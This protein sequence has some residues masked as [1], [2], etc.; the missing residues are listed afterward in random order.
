M[1]PA[2]RRPEPGPQ[3]GAE[4]RPLSIK[5]EGTFAST[6]KQTVNNGRHLSYAE[7]SAM[8]AE[9]VAGRPVK[10]A[11][12]GGNSLATLPTKHG[13]SGECKGGRDV[14]SYRRTP[15]E[16]KYPRRDKDVTVCTTGGGHFITHP[17]A[18]SK[19]GG[20]P[21]LTAKGTGSLSVPVA[22]EEAAQRRT[23]PGAPGDVS[24]PMGGTPTTTTPSNAQVEKVV[25][26]GERRNKTPVCVS[27]VKNPRSFRNVF[28]QSPRA[29][30]WPT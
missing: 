25:F 9:V 24:G 20:P 1:E 13:A 3:S 7:V 22:S 2:A 15:P 11:N 12:A 10:G 29:S 17:T 14:K 23:S 18:L 30:L 16:T 26:T 5:L 19:P 6:G 8:Y 27:G 28:A 4:S 21:K